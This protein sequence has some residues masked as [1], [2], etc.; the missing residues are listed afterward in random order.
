MKERKKERAEKRRKKNRGEN[1]ERKEGAEAQKKTESKICRYSFQLL[2][3]VIFR[4]GTVGLCYPKTRLFFCSRY[5][6]S[7]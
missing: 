7:V 4:L 3:F 2:F 5:L 6:V 1:G